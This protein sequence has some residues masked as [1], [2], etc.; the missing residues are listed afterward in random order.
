VTNECTTIGAGSSCVAS[1]ASNMAGYHN[2]Q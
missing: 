1:T 2:C